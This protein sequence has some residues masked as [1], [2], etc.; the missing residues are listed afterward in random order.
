MKALACLACAIDRFNQTIGMAVAWF[1]LFMV[2]VQF[3]V[4]VL[5]Y[6]FGY[7]SIFMQESI[8]YMHGF[9]FLI[10]SGYTLLHGGHVR[11]D[12]F[13][14]EASPRKKAAIDLFGVVTLLAPVCI[15]M[16][17]Y[18]WPYVANS[19][20]ILETSKETSGIPAVFV[21]KSAMVAFLILMLLQGLSMAIHSLRILAGQEQ[22]PINEEHEV[23]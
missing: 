21:L 23:L 9:L 5:R 15:G 8:I 16:M 2:I 6:V 11:V 3:L 20:S 4:V 14:R 13:Y 17:Y 22:P 10:G 18:T 1:A 19:W 12:I 7:G